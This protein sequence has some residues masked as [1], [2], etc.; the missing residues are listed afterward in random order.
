MDPPW[1]R[2]AHGGAIH[3][4]A[5][6]PDRFPPHLRLWLAPTI[7]QLRQPEA[8]PASVDASAARTGGSRADDPLDC[9][10]CGRGD[11]VGWAR[12]AA[13]GSGCRPAIRAT[14][15]ASARSAAR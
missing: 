3:G 13:A 4:A 2:D 15:G 5:I 6:G 10:H 8:T 1:C 9:N 7:P 14:I 11:A 12:V